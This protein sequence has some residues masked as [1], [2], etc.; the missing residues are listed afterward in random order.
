MVGKLGWGNFSTVWQCKDQV[1]NSQVAV[2]VNKSHRDVTEMA[3]DEIKLLKCIGKASTSHPGS[4]HVLR[5][6]EHFEVE[7]PN[8]RHVCLSL[9]LLGYSLLRCYKPGQEG[10]PLEKVKEVMNQVMLGLDFLHTKAKIIH[11][12]IKPENILLS[13][14]GAVDLSSIGGSLLKVKIGDLGSACWTT[15]RFS[16]SI[17]TREYRA[18]EALL[19]VEDYGTEV[20]VWAAAC[21]AFELAT[22]EYLF[23]PKEREEWSRDEDHLLRITELVGHLPKAV[24]KAGFHGP[25]YYE[26]R[27]LKN[28]DQGILRPYSLFQVVTSLPIFVSELNV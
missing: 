27:K 5:L 21:T 28:I 19:G 18:P 16:V 10:M 15:K 4:K 13:E 1:E 2:K 24:I 3:E 25:T 14:P 12:D 23:K 26:G 8:G 7:G 9:Q 20:D 17:G 6:V 22:G 11:T